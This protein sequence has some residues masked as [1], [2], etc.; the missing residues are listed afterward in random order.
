MPIEFSTSLELDLLFARW[1]GRVDFEQFEQNFV[2]YLGDAHYRPG[3]P[4]LID[5]SGITE[6]DINLNYVKSIL[7]Q[8]NEQAPGT[9]VKT[10]TV[11]Y[12]PNETVYG[13]GRMYQTLADMADGIQ[14]EVYQTE[15]EALDALELPHSSIEQLL[16]AETFLPPTP[17]AG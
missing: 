16:A 1:H 2:R 11:L 9:L 13:I 6:M 10:R 15:R 12:S 8:V 7:R 17:R 5:H 14:V 3:R 4:E